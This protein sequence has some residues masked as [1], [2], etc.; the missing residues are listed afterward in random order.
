MKRFVQIP[1]PR[2]ILALSCL[3]L[4]S[5]GGGGG[6]GGGGTSF[7][8]SGTGQATGMTLAEMCTPAVIQSIL[9][10]GATVKDIPNML[11]ALPAEM[12]ATKG[13]TVLIQANAF[14]DG[15][16]AYCV[17]TG[18]F[19]TNPE[20]KKTA[21]FGAVFPAPDQWNGKYLQIACGGNCGSVFDAGIPTPAHV[22]AGYAMWHT[23]DGHVDRAIAESGFSV[24]ADSSWAVLSP[25]VPNVDAIE[26]YLHRAVHSLAQVGPRAT[27]ALYG[28]EKVQRS[29]LMGCS[30][31]GREGMVQATKYPD[32]FDG[33]VA[34]APYSMVRSNFSFMKR[35]LAQFRSPGAALSQAQVD[36]VAKAALDVCDASDGVTDGLVQAPNACNFD[37][38]K[39]VALCPAG[40]SGADCLTTEQMESV[41][42]FLT[43]VSDSAGNTV[44]A[45][46]APV[47][48]K[49]PESIAYVFPS[50]PVPGPDP[51]GPEPYLTMFT[52][53]SISNYTLRNQV[54][55]GA[56]DYNGL[57]SL[58]MTFGLA[59]GSDPSSFQASVPSPIV[60]RVAAA[61]KT[62]L[63][64][65]PSAASTFIAKDR[66]LIMYHGLE[67]ALLNPNDTMRYYQALAARQGGYRALQN[68]VR[69]FMAPGVN[70]CVGGPG[71]NAFVNHYNAPNFF[72]GPPVPFD[73][74]HD[75][76]AA[77]DAWVEKGTPPQS[78]IATKYTDNDSS[79]PI[80]RT[81]PLCPFPSKAQYK[82]SGSINDAVNWSCSAVDASLLEQ[83]LAG[84]R[85][86]MQT[87]LTI[88]NQN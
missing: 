66:K 27:A 47:V 21:N 69:L 20:T 79:K 87:V 35:Q 83:G 44:T 50:T 70:H 5:C 23:D 29:Y 51:F 85:A 73:P 53:W 36:L 75:A 71:P 72:S 62:G 60:Q 52:D 86:G 45:G 46:W 32:D 24:E 13:G 22:R 64:D 10:A 43:P 54:F 57:T 48:F 3:V 39:S 31:G 56:S 8:G 1:M 49:S 4:C 7:P 76:L 77:L 9:P 55:A 59:N 2:W 38:R 58:G 28:A 26:D 11:T 61:F 6:G 78:I 65:D 33:I 25:G 16:P 12:R 88:F 37:V 84:V 63:W 19:T 18:S 80:Q 15:A 81:M 82:G 40:Q 74:S 34:G 68:N 14:G 17:A 67:D 30:D 42:A 41:E